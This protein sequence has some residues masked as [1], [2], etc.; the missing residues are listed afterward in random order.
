MQFDSIFAEALHY[1]PEMA[2]FLPSIS[3]DG[4]TDSTKSFEIYIEQNT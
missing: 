4:L 2:M 3:K 1:C